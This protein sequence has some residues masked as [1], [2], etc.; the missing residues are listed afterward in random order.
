MLPLTFA[1]HIAFPRRLHLTS[2]SLGEAMSLKPV[3][4]L[5]LHA[6]RTCMCVCVCVCVCRTMFATRNPMAAALVQTHRRLQISG[7]SP[8]RH[9]LPI[10]SSQHS[11]G[12]HNDMQHDI[13]RTRRP[14]RFLRKNRDQL[15]CTQL[16]P[17]I[18]AIAQCRPS[19]EIGI[20][21]QSA[22][23][24]NGPSGRISAFSP[25]SVGFV[26]TRDGGLGREWV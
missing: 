12:F 10:N 7:Q 8:S 20:K 19:N 25:S 5:F 23:Q 3:W 6:S 1:H 21:A 14:L 15:F 9:C 17:E 11:A 2:R 22:L 24:R 18:R 26:T 4:S 16:L 13:N